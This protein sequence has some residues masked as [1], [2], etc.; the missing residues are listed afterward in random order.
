M[1]YEPIPSTSREVRLASRPSGAKIT[2]D[3]FTVAEVPISEPP[4]GSGMVVVRNDFVVLGAVARDLMEEEHNLPLPSFKIGEA[5]WG[6][7]IGTVVRSDSPDLAVGDLVEHFFGVRDYLI[8]PPQAFFKRDRDLL[9]GPEYYMSQGVTAWHGMVDI[10]NV[11]K[12]DVVYVS[13]AAGGVGS[14]AG[15]IAKNLGAKKV[16]GSAGSKE[17]VQ[18]LLEELKFDVAFNYREGD[19]AEQL[20]QAAP[21]GLTVVF[22]NVGG[23]QFEACIQNAAWQ[24]RFALC[25][26]LS[27]QTGAD[28]PRIDLMTVIP[29]SISLHGF[30]AMHTPEQI[31]DWNK[32]FGAWLKEGKIVYSHT[33]VEGGAAAWPEAQAA[34]LDGKYSGVVVVKF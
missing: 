25:G 20:G 22:D 7:G 10:V 6:R 27:G 1:S 15:Q 28:N 21:E 19:F 34:L 31:E 4:A 3:N 14:M 33:V 8:G 29:R 5:I 18:Y 30:A 17:K 23:A 32:Q 24:A 2:P 26:S 11:G 13:G 16:I 9:P 12:D